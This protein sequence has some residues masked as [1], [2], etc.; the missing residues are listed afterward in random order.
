MQDQRFWGIVNQHIKGD[1]YRLLENR[2]GWVLLGNKKVVGNRGARIIRFH[3]V[4][5][6]VRITP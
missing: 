1:K 5:D 4:D 6:K 2:R 3:V